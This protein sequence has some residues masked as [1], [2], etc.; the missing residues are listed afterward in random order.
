M[1]IC[2]QIISARIKKADP[3]K[4]SQ[5]ATLKKQLEDWANK[6]DIIIEPQSEILK[7]RKKLMVAKTFY[8]CG[9]VVPV[10]KKTQVGYRK[11]PETDGKKT[12]FHVNSCEL[13]TE[14]YFYLLP[15][16]T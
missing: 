12:S 3:F 2:S 4:K 7:K 11:I 5:L 9:I 14:T 16:L 10:D 6:N 8:E 13:N 15:Q 1:F